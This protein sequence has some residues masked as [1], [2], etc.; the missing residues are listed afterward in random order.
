MPLAWLHPDGNVSIGLIKMAS[1]LKSGLLLLTVCTVLTDVSFYLNDYS[2][3]Q[4][5]MCF[6]LTV[7][8]FYLCRFTT[9]SMS[10]WIIWMHIVDRSGNDVMYIIRYIN[11][12]MRIS[13]ELNRTSLEDLILVSFYLS[14]PKLSWD[15]MEASSSGFQFKL[16]LFLSF[17][18]HL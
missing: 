16:K 17:W 10:V 9:Q 2:F 3:K 1:N 5:T 18:K 12:Y 7:V 11:G 4:L 6:L 14:D 15:Q 13:C 8:V